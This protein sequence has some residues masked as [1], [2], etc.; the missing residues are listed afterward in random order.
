METQARPT[1]YYEYPN[2]EDLQPPAS[3]Q[4]LGPILMKDP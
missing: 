2:E 3:R 1:K 4:E